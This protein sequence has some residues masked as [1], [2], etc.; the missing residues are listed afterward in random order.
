MI[1][2]DRQSLIASQNS[3]LN[4]IYKDVN[5]FV[6]LG[7]GLVTLV[8]AMAIYFFS[9]T[10]GLWMEAVVVFLCAMYYMIM[11]FVKEKMALGYYQK[12]KEIRVRWTKQGIAIKEF[13][14]DAQIDSLVGFTQIKRVTEYNHYIEIKLKNE[15]V[16]TLPN[17]DDCTE[18][19]EVLQNK[20][21]SLYRVREY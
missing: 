11:S 6:W 1:I 9:I 2:F 5:F 13:T 14:K 15:G 19:K 21:K 12:T 20:L 16:V 8:V 4:H 10:I 7:W 17:T 18:L 3:K